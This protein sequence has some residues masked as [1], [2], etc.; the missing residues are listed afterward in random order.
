MSEK[1]E[2]LRELKALLEKHKCELEADDLWQ[3][4]PECGQD[5]QISVSFKS[6]DI[7]LGQSIC[8]VTI[9]SVIEGLSP[10]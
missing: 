5:I 8:P 1:I 4:Y 9:D 3:G 2:F 7:Y 10:Q 6:D